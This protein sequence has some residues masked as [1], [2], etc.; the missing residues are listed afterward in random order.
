MFEENFYFKE[1][2][3]LFLQNISKQRCYSPYYLWEMVIYFCM[4]QLFSLSLPLFFFFF[5]TL[6]RYLNTQTISS[7]GS[8]ACH[9]I[10]RGVYLV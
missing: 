7:Q 3:E 9:F 2:F 5:F 6:F 1:G 8:L 4:T 10:A